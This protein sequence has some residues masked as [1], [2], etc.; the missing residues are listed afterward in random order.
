MKQTHGQTVQRTF[1]G[2]R[3][4][5]FGMHTQLMKP[6]QVTPRLIILWPWLWPLYKKSQFGHCFH[7][8]I[9]TFQT[10]LVICSVCL[11]LSL[12]LFFLFFWGGGGGCLLI[13]KVDENCYSSH[14]YVTA[15][16]C[17]KLR[18][19]VGIHAID[20]VAKLRYLSPSFR[21]RTQIPWLATMRHW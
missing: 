1:S 10:R 11:F 18:L 9:P 13:A 16:K 5:I 4:F 6:F 3:D 12:F 14:M 19:T 2:D 8:G 7:R 15:C 17:L 21:R 20:I